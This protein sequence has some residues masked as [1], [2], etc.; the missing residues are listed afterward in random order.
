MKTKDY[1]VFFSIFAI[2]LVLIFSFIQVVSFADNGDPPYK[3]GDDVNSVCTCN[4]QSESVSFTNMSDT[5]KSRIIISQNEV[6]KTV[7]VEGA[8]IKKN[9]VDL[10]P[11]EEVSASLPADYINDENYK[12]TYIYTKENFK[13]PVEAGEKAGSIIISYNNDIIE[14]YDIVTAEAVPRDNFIFILDS[15]REFISSRLF[16]STVICF[17]ILLLTYTFVVPG[18]ARRPKNKYYEYKNFK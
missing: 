5:F 18:F 3:I 11:G 2:C 16:I 17:F 15:I 8:S 9:T 12:I 6:L 13:A 7:P 1:T 10:V 14:I 4:L